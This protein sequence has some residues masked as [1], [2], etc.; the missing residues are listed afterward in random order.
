MR[1]GRRKEGKK[2]MK[3][4]RE[5]F[6]KG[7]ERERRKKGKIKKIDRRLEVRERKGRQ[8]KS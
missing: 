3:L 6:K 4:W 5:S 2:G 1:K 8:G 7:V